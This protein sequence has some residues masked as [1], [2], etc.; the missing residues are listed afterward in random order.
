MFHSDD[1]D[2]DGLGPTWEKERVKLY[3]W[4][5][6]PQHNWRN[7]IIIPMQQW[8]R[9][10][11]QA[12]ELAKFVQVIKC[13]F[14][15]GNSLRDILCI[16]VVFVGIIIIIIYSRSLGTSIRFTSLHLNVARRCSWPGSKKKLLNK[17]RSERSW[18][19]EECGWLIVEID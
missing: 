11:V 9:R 7:I 19:E 12:W 5:Y 8:R 14:Q 4:I 18:R 1:D 10:K 13:E 3:S 15:T 6:R 2:D 16:E 17:F